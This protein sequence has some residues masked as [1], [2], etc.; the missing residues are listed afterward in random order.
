MPPRTGHVVAGLLFSVQEGLVGFVVV[1]HSICFY[2]YFLYF[3]PV[4]LI[5]LSS[6]KSQVSLMLWIEVIRARF[7]GL[8]EPGAVI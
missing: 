2:F 7:W 3:A 8:S 6:A 4:S 5:Y 1:A